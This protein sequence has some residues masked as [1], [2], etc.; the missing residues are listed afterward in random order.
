M[1]ARLGGPD[2]LLGF[3]VQAEPIRPLLELALAKAAQEDPDAAAALAFLDPQSLESLAG[4]LAV[5]P[6]G[7]ALDLGLQLAE[8]HRNLAFNL[9][10]LPSV[11]RDTLELVPEGAAFF[12]AAALN[13]RAP[14]APAAEAGAPIVTFMD[15]GREVFA[16]VVDVAVFG[17]PPAAGEAVTGLPDVACVVRANDVARS[18][19][20]WNFV[21]G[22]ASSSSAGG[23]I[24]PERVEIAGV[25]SE[26][27]A[28]EGV[29]MHLV[30]IE[31]GLLISPSRSALERS[32]AALRADRSVLGDEV[33]RKALSRPEGRDTLL[34]VAN[35]GRCARMAAALAPSSETARLAAFAD[36][37]QRTV[38]A[39]GL[40]QTDTRL[41][42]RAR[43]SDVPDISRFVLQ[44]SGA[45][46]RPRS[47]EKLAGGN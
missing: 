19:A 32:L 37:L 36:A 2:A 23:S 12:A 40:E 26:R 42:L 8:G 45:L 1:R 47:E 11:G 43:L 30:P 44:G 4:R 14:A 20:M 13:R 35:P 33:F 29:P 16:N 27:Y 9:L 18:K 21:L 15:F 41:G 6:D 39:V 22:L 25:P 3:F 10:R 24:D 17:L 31:Q 5:A 34:V 28:L 46:G 38:L 7:V